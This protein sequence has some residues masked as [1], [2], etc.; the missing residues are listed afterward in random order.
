MRDDIDYS[1]KY[2]QDVDY[3]T[4]SNEFRYSF[5]HFKSLQQNQE[6]RMNSYS[7]D[8][9]WR[10]VKVEFDRD[11]GF[12]RS[13][14]IRVR[15]AYRNGSTLPYTIDRID[16]TKERRRGSLLVLSQVPNDGYKSLDLGSPDGV[17]PVGASC[18]RDLFTYQL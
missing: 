7:P 4:K 13:Y 16:L 10:D 5:S 8:R 3:Y 18:A 9:I 12:P 1:D 11:I 14:G 17:L 2:Y 6:Q 15:T